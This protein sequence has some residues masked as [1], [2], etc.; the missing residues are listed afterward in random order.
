MLSIVCS[1]KWGH[2]YGELH[3]LD[4]QAYKTAKGAFRNH[5]CPIWANDCLENT[6]KEQKKFFLKKKIT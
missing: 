4:G 1:D 3:R 2:G 5:P 6:K